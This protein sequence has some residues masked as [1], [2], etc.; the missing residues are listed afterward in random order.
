VF[1]QTRTDKEGRPL[2]D[3]DSTTYV[4]AIEGAEEFGLRL[5]TEA[6][7]R[8]WS[9]AGKKVVLGDGA[10]WIWNLSAQHFPGAIQ[11]VDLYHARQHLWELSAKLFP[12]DQ[13]A[14]MRWMGRGLQQ[15][16]QG[17]VESLVKTLQD[18]QLGDRELA[19][20]VASLDRK[21]LGAEN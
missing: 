21:C 16:D 12:Q 9:G 5:Y 19:R 2:R 1:T 6:W 15:L 10:V 17:Q 3:Q 8:G 4:A 13:K 7:Q 18:L 20:L 14:R 11:I